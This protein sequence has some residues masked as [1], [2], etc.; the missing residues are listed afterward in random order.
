MN[1]SKLFQIVNKPHLYSPGNSFMWNDPHISQYLLETHL[2]EDIDLASRRRSQINKTIKWITEQLPQRT[3]NILDL[4][5]G[6]GLYTETYAEMGHHVTGVDISNNSIEYAIS[7][8]K[9]K[10][11]TIHYQAC[12]YLQLELIPSHYDLIMMI[13]T[14]MG[15]LTPKDRNKLL[16]TISTSLKPGGILIFDVMRDSGL[17]QKVTPPSWDAEPQ[18]GFWNS[19]PYIALSNSFLYDE[20]KVILYQHVILQ[21]DKDPVYYRFWTHYFSPKDLE[22]ML[23]P[24]P[25]SE[26]DISDN[27]LDENDQWS[28]HNVLFCKS[29]KR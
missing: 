18:G 25:L 2:N 4:G 20:Q 19:D 3:L 5:C 29:V 13:Y 24:Y 27:V 17:E 6:P 1:V 11:L 8:A 14:D 12:D 21:H 23:S 15:V 7:N 16:K 22:D 28:G 10:G 9:K 26:I